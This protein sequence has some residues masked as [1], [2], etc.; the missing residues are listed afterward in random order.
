M[1]AA[2]AAVAAVAATVAATV[3][4]CAEATAANAEP[5]S[6]QGL[7]GEN[8]HETAA[9]CILRMPFAFYGQSTPGNTVLVYW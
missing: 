1:A 9:A 5:A 4:A 3:A 2:G 8:E 6:E 7:P